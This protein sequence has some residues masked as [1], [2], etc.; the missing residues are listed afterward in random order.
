MEY[1]RA[2]NR[3]DEFMRD[4]RNG[5]TSGG[6]NDFD[7]DYYQARWEESGV[8]EADCLICHQPGYKNEERKKQLKA[9]NFRWAP[10][11]AI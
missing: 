8:L 2:G 1:D 3:Y 4:E 5:L 11:T 6:D 7:G 9:L 10:T